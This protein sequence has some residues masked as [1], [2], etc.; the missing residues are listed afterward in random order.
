MIYLLGLRCQLADWRSVILRLRSSVAR[1]PPSLWP[2]D[3]H[4]SYHSKDTVYL[5]PI[6]APACSC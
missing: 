6:G 3:E 5:L 2:Y 4:P 1:L